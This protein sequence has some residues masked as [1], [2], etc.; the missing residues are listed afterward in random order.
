MEA[1]AQALVRVLWEARH[2]GFLGPGAVESHIAHARAFV[3]AAG[4]EPRRFLD[5]GSGGGIPGLVCALAWPSASGVLL[6][7]SERRTRFLEEACAALGVRERVAVVRARAEDAARDP[8]LRCGFTVVTARGFGPPA[9][10]AECGGAFVEMG[11]LLVVSDPPE[12]DARRWPDAGLALLGLA[13]EE[14]PA[15]GGSG[16][17]LMRLRRVAP[18]DG[19]WPRRVGVPAKRPLWRVEG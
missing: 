15:D 1:G 10:T 5:L 6:D 12:P 8:D 3:A 16:V 17:R 18:L 14:G 13:R 7:A 9:V 4:T 11:G 2:R 19:R